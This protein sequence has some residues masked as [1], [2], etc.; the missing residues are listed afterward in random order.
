VRKFGRNVLLGLVRT[1]RTE[2]KVLGLDGGKLG[3][4]GVDVLEVEQGNLLVQDLGE[5]IDANGLLAGGTE[6]DVLLAESSVL[7]LEEGDL[8]EHLVGERAGHDER[9]V[10]GGTAKV[11][12]TS[13][14]QQNDMA[15]VGHSITVNLRLDVLDRLGIGLEPGNVN[16]DIEVAD[17]CSC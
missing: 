5:D 11:N 13:L 8:S 10:T 3:Q 2:T 12:Q 16:L 6:L 1:V 4:L 9:G 14:S 17:V 15:S 7:G